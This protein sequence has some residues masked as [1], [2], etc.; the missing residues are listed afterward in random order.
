MWFSR[1]KH[2]KGSGVTDSQ[3]THSDTHTLW[4]TLRMRSSSGVRHSLVVF[5]AN[6][7]WLRV[8]LKPEVQVCNSSLMWEVCVGISTSSE[9]H[10]SRS[11]D[12]LQKMWGLLDPA[13]SWGYRFSAE[14]ESFYFWRRLR[15]FSSSNLCSF[16]WVLLCGLSHVLNCR[17]CGETSQ[18]GI[19]NQTGNSFK[20]SIT[21]PSTTSLLELTWTFTLSSPGCS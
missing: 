18:D 15:I 9:T 7:V 12:G 13:V 19:H 17:T 5:S 14:V 21:P 10:S 2:H 3:Q 6:Y 20:E 8:W 1:S 16:M 4:H 11:T